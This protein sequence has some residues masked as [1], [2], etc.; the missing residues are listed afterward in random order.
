MKV[1]VSYLFLSAAIVFTLSCRSHKPA[2]YYPVPAEPETTSTAKPGEKPNDMQ[3]EISE[4]MLNKCF[5]ALGPIKGKEPYKVLFYNDTFTWVLMNPQ[6]RLHKGKADFTTT[7]GV[8]AGKFA[9]S[10]PCNGDVKIW[11]DRPKNLINVKINRCI[12]EIYTKIM[13]TKYHIKDIDIADNFKDPFTFEGPTA[14][15]TDMEMEMP[16]GTIRKLYMTTTDCDLTVE[17][18]KIVVPCE[19]GF[20]LTPPKK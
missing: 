6:I 5:K 14:T 13:G 16:D 18:K 19:V 20:S 10:A 1:F 11:Y 3:I 15:S 7:V 2:T 9:Y 8:V 12:L 17:E 4:E